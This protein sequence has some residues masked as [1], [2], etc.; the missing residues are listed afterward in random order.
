MSSAEKVKN[1][2][3][4][5][6]PRLE[7]FKRFQKEGMIPMHGDF[8]A[9]GVHYPPIT[10]YAPITQEEMFRNYTLPED[11]LLD[12][13]VHIPFCIKRCI[14]CHYPSLYHA[15]SPKKDMYLDALEKEMD[16]YMRVLGIDMI[17]ARSI[18]IGGG[19]P[20][21]L[22]PDQ[23]KRFLEFFTKRVNLDKCKQ[24]NY[25]VDPATLI[26]SDGIE[27][28]RIMRDF[29]VDR[30]TI[31]VQS[32]ND[33]ILKRMNRSHDAREAIESV[34]NSKKFG[35]Q[36]NIEFIF[37]HP[38]QTIE[39]WIETLEEALKLDTPELQFY[40][41][42]VEPYGDQE[43]VIK[44]FRQYHPDEL[45]KPEEAILMK[46]IAI[47]LLAEH[48]YNENL[49][50]VFTKKRS[51]ISLYAF[52][53]C[54]QLLDEIGIGLTAFS[55]LRDRFVLNTQYFEEYYKCI[56]EGRLPLNRGILRNKE[57]QMRWSVILPLKNYFIRKKLFEKVNGF[58]IDNVFQDKFSVLKDYGLITEN[59][60]MIELTKLGAF[61][62][63]EVV[64]QF[65]DK[66]Y[67]PFPEPDYS[68]GPLN[69]YRQTATV[70]T[71]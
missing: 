31:G 54:C 47:E 10:M 9:S 4:K 34:E 6:L 22:T 27:R 62:A 41:L 18:L 26:H 46:Q 29:G 58:S 63:D 64:Q 33:K 39:N 35:Y 51:Y 57:Q 7:D 60:N 56:E 30:L 59:E 50:R 21:D 36:I 15:A 17:N 25:D 23:L 16:I 49:R 13:Y 3:E 48:G 70:V 8:F 67:I 24:F 20:T 68:D 43:G 32:L 66:A 55:S 14:F 71:P 61:F 37:G 69:P 1:L 40:R 5:A 11:G 52:N 65:H 12:V 19:T 53:Q 28:L 42:K 44:K 38:G 2:T 45:P